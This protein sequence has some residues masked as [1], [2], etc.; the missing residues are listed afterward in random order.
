MGDKLSGAEIAALSRLVSVGD[1]GLAARGGAGL[2]N[3]ELAGLGLSGREIR[4]LKEKLEPREVPDYELDL[5]QMRDP[6]DVAAE[7]DK[8][9]PEVDRG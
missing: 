5:T 6:Q 1:D 7:M 3:A 2:T 9:V 8:A 4:E